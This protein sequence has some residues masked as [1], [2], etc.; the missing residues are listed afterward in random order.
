M[1]RYVNEYT[2]DK[3]LFLISEASGF[4]K[5]IIANADT[6][7]IYERA[8]NFFNHF[9]IDEFQD[10][11]AIQW[12][13]FRPL[14]ADSIASGNSNWI[15]GDVKQSIYRWRNTDWKILSEQVIDNLGAHNV[16][17]LNLD[18][19]WRSAPEIVQF[20]NVFF[21][22]AI[23]QMRTAFLNDEKDGSNEEYLQSLTAA[24]T[25]AYRDVYQHVRPSEKKGYVYLEMIAEEEE[26]TWRENVLEELPRRLE[27][28]QDLGYGLSDIAILV[29][30]NKEAREIADTLIAYRNANPDSKY[31]Y[32]V[33]SNE[34]L[35][36]CNAP[37][38]K[39]IV[40]AMRYI[41]E[42]DDLINRACLQH[43]HDTHF[44]SESNKS[45]IQSLSHSVTQLFSTPVY[46]LSNKL[47]NQFN[48]YKNIGQAPF[49]Q[50]F[51]D[52]L[53]QYV[54]R[55]ASDIRSFL[56]WWNDKKDKKYISMPDN[57][58][59]IRLVTIHK[60]KGLEFEVVI[61]PFCD[62]SLCKS[63]KTL[64]LRPD[65]KPFSDMKLLPLKFEHSL[66]NTI[67]IK[68]YQRE[69]ML[70]YIDNL[71]LLYVAFTRARKALYISMPQQ[72]KDEFSDVKNLIFRVFNENLELR[73]C[74]I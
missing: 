34:S 13:N 64:W 20:N 29:R 46:E 41:V 4:L 62:W 70:S 59:A 22:E 57:Q 43:L 6:P 23:L 48:L 18:K 73:D 27:K 68:D 38:V 25:E 54:R 16:K 42:P 17:V 32:D 39:W 30:E 47:I 74:L 58:D 49:L 63:G 71:N 61:I 2:R 52:I 66:R 8:G 10:T 50:A 31:R 53:L 26:K 44:K 72:K 35:L 45:I 11:S 9:M 60:S 33:L 24:M 19:N 37:S 3:N 1:M 51:Q 65:E 15:V 5:K 36:I 14:I 69:K 56:N 7:F 12:D 67:F 28:L 55:E 21:K 40:A